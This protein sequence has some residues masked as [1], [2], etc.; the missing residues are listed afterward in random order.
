LVLSWHGEDLRNVQVGGRGCEE[1]GR[2]DAEAGGR[3]GLATMVTGA[4]LLVALFLSPLVGTV[5]AGYPVAG[6]AIHP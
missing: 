4:L 2:T 1:D 3:T 6:S 5:A